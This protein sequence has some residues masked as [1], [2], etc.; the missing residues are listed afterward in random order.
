MN[1]G[2]YQNDDSIIKKALDILN[3]SVSLGWDKKYGGLFYFIDIKGRPTEQIEWDMKLWWPHT[4]AL[5]A[6][7]LAYSITQDD[8]Y[9]RQYGMVH[10]WAF[11]KF[12][13]IINGEWFGYLHRDG[14]Q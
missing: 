8:N 2:I 4:E 10:K 9:F 7:L 3:W 14:E 11:G 13:D 6:L 12:A 1:E 5:H